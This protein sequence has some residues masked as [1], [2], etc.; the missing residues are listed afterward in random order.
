MIV[1]DRTISV[2]KS[3]YYA[4]SGDT[5]MII[6]RVIIARVDDLMYSFSLEA[7][8]AYIAKRLIENGRLFTICE[9]MLPLTSDIRKVFMELKQG[10][11]CERKNSER[12]EHV[13]DKLVAFVDGGG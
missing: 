7:D 12:L 4:S 5:E 2:S 1:V 10:V 9:R 11:L 13:V 3:L 6:A 8:K